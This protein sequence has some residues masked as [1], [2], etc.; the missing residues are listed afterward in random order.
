MFGKLVPVYREKESFTLFYDTDKK[1]LY[2]FPHRGKIGGFSWFYLL[3]LLVLYVSSFLNDLYQ[4]YGS[5]VLNLVCSI[6]L[7]PIGYSIARV[8]YKGYYI[9]NKN[10][11]YYL[12]QENLLNYEEQGKKQFVRECIGTLCSIVVM[13]IGFV[14]FFVFNQLQGLIIGGIGYIVVWIFLLMNPYSRLQLYKKIQRG[15]IKL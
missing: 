3:P 2:R 7:L 5:L 10:C 12:D 8:F 9:Q 13:I 11:G 4:P 6:I 15:E 14:V 1:Q